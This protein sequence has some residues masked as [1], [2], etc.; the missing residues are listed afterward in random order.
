LDRLE[1][2]RRPGAADQLAVTTGS[3]GPGRPALVPLSTASTLDA[4]G[5]PIG[6]VA[7]LFETW[8]LLRQAS[9]RIA[10][11]RTID[12]YR[13]DMARWAFL[14]AAPGGGAALDRWV[15]N[16]L[17][18]E[19]IQRAL[20]EM[21]RAG[22]S[23]SARQRALSPLRG[24]CRWLVR[25]GRM[26]VD[27]TQDEEL[28]VRGSSQRLP[29]AFSKAE[30]ARI[31]EVV[32]DGSGRQHD[33]ARWPERD[34]AALSLLAGCGLRASEA[35]GLRWS[36]LADLDEPEPGVR[37]VGKGSGER[38]VPLAP[39][40][41]HVLRTYRD[42]RR[43]LYRRGPLRVS[44][45]AQV[46]VRVDG[47]PVTSSVL[48][49]WAKRWLIEA[50]VAR[51]PGALVHA[52]RHTAADGW[53]ANGATIAE[54]QALLGHV[55]IAT[56]G[57]YTKGRPETLIRVV[58]VGRLEGVLALTRLDSRGDSGRHEEASSPR[59]TPT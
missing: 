43:A 42:G 11:T 28:S 50:N 51:R 57:I 8:L 34:L 13:A 35:C 49:G 12:G 45:E 23:V 9:N 6:E 21:S 32:R 20:A 47:R 48:T 33:A 15:L 1:L 52:F 22:L 54:V 3:A 41:V 39:H 44:A 31:T 17:T 16:D 56:T 58:R 18:S 38:R 27:P 30:I 25:S 36:G 2:E 40:I 4:S 53:L 19:T 14:L 7:R 37:V 24:F 59:G 46:L 26:R 29:A 5:Q 55:S 10:S